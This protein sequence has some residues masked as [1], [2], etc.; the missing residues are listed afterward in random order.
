MDRSLLERMIGAAVLVIVLV[1]VAPALLDG[2]GDAPV[3]EQQPD[4][5]E[6]PTQVA[7]V[8]VKTIRLGK[9]AMPD[10]VPEPVT[11]PSAKS[12][13]SSEP[14]G[15]P[16]ASV[17]VNTNDW[18]VQL[19]SFSAED[20]ARKFANVLQKQKFPA[21]VTS[22]RSGANTMYRVQV[23]PRPDREAAEKLAEQLKRA[24]HNGIVVQLRP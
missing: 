2:R 15:K 17:P 23:G 20:N 5:M 11:E 9:E 7:P 12:V 21:K 3:T 4:I 16:A 8:Q 10:A 18:M 13:T 24:G 1:V 14:A 22:F 19:G 6:A